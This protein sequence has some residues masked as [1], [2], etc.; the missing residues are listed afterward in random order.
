MADWGKILEGAGYGVKAT[1]SIFG[2]IFS[3]RAARK[4][5]RRINEQ[6]DSQERRA[7]SEFES[8]YYADPSQLAGNQLALTEMQRYLREQRQSRAAANAVTGGSEESVAAAKAV[9]NQTVGNLAANIGAS[10][11]ARRNALRDQYNNVLTG[12]SNA[13]IAQIQNEG[14][15]KQQNIGNWMNTM[16]QI[17]NS[18]IASGQG[19]QMGNGAGGA[20]K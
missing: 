13:R 8:Q 19:M 14:N 16:N 18:M 1:G 12:V 7:N 17:G 9:D 5:N 10:T 4:T 11:E 3:S 2:N 15:Q 6:L 20:G